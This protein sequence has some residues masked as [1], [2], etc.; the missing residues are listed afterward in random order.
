MQLAEIQNGRLAMMAITGFAYQELFTNVA[1]IHQL[2][3]IHF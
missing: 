3:L 1:V 2:P